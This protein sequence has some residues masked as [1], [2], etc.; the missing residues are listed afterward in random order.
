VGY[1]RKKLPSGPFLLLAEKNRLLGIRQAVAGKLNIHD[2]L[3]LY[4]LWSLCIKWLS[5]LETAE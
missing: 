2:I 1:E 4:S 3:K 5:G